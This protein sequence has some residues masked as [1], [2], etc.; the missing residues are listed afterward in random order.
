[1]GETTTQ[2]G[3]PNRKRQT[4][5]FKKITNEKETCWS[6]RQVGDPDS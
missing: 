5:R 2:F 3:R 1:M 4:T 6:R